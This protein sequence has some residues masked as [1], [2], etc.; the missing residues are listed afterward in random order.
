MHGRYGAAGLKLRNSSLCDPQNSIEIAFITDHSAA[1]SSFFVSIDTLLLLIVSIG[2]VRT[3]R[4]HQVNEP[5]K[6]PFT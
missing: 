4:V 2:F 3:S 6:L 5:E 1:S